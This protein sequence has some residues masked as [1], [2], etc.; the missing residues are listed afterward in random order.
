MSR[1]W[2][3]EEVKALKE[4]VRLGVQMRDLQKVLK[5][6]TRKAI[7]NKMSELG[8]SLAGEGAIDKEYYL[9][10]KRVYKV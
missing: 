5:D 9:K 1:K 7:S 4:L 10:I 8:L 3:N 2:S 6:R